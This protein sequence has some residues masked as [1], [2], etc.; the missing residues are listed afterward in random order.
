MSFKLLSISSMYSGYLQSFYRKYPITGKLSY[1]DHYELLM[2]DT[3]EFAGSYTRNFRK[4]GIDAKCIVAN[5][6]DLQRKWKSENNLKSEKNSDI[7]FEQV[8][9]FKPEILWIEDLSCLSEDW[10][11]NIRNKIRTLRR[12]I[13]YHCAPY[14]K[15][16]LD[17]MRNVDFVITCTPGLK[18]GF[19]NEGL[20]SYLV[21]HGFDNDLLPR[22][23]SVND[24]QVLNLVFSGSLITGG[25]FHNSRINLIESLLKEEID[26]DLYV[27]LEKEYKIKAKQF[28]YLLNNFSKKLKLERFTDRIPFFEHGRSPIT[29][30]SHELLRSNHQPLYGIDM[31]NLFNKAKIILNIH[32]GVAGEYA[33]NMRL[34]EV[35]GVGSCLLTDYK[36]NLKDLFDVDKEV[37]VYNSQEDCIEKVKWLLENENQ[38]KE[39]AQLGQKRTLESHTV[40][41][42]CKTII[43]LINSE[44]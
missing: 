36:R 19:E 29:G 11:R 30:Y 33:G 13:V 8:A 14:S 12:I 40:G 16:T 39:I 18:A 28:I 41:D 20:R 43:D 17:K 1:N 21:Y 37:V 42:R 32:I 23:N 9:Y 24:T 4:L 2:S 25:S 15:S 3:T 38:R 22:I 27:T 31:Y 10:F 44:L 34:F 6:I 26:L 5:D 7:L 35:T